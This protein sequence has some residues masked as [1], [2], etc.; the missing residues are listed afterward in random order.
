MF[1]ARLW[2]CALTLLLACILSGAALAE[3]PTLVGRI[4]VTK[5]AAATI[6]DGQHEWMRR[7][8]A[9]IETRSG[10]RIKA[11][12]YQRASSARFRA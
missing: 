4:Y 10:G 3:N 5:L 9:A 11:E 7:F 2:R 12:I 8:A 6:N 1:A